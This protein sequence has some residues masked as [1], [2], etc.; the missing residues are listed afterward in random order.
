MSLKPEH[1]AKINVFEKLNQTER[2]GLVQLARRRSVS[3]GEILCHQ[4]DIWPFV[5]Y[6]AYGQLRSSIASPDGKSYI[7]TT[8]EAGDVF[9]AH[10]IFDQLPMPSTLEAVCASTLYQWDGDAAL[11]IVLRN[12][13]AMRA[14]LERQTSLIRKRREN[15][16]SLVFNPVVS[17]LAKL[18]V[19]KFDTLD[20]AT[21]QRDLT[22]DEMA[23]MVATSPVVVCRLLY[24][25]QAEGILTVKRASITLN[26]RNALVK[27]T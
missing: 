19:G 27:L 25:F 13:A 16:Y 7:I 26:D 10:T 8:W 18:I 9:W 24:Q 5:V 21:M 20:N 1:L 6:T 22:L 15:I 11:E 12:P 4:E 17:R 23:G 14:L 2:E 3:K